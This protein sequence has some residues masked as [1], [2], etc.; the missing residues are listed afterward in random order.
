MGEGCMRG[1]ICL[2]KPSFCDCKKVK[3]VGDKKIMDR[4]EL[5]ADKNGHS[6]GHMTRGGWFL[7]AGGLR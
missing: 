2:L 5:I 4:S 7:G 3:G 6:R 1:R